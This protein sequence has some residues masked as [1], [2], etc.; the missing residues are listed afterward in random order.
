M[1]RF[2][3]FILSSSS[4]NQSLDFNTTIWTVFRSVYVRFFDFNEELKQTAVR[5]EIFPNYAKELLRV[6]DHPK[7]G[8]CI[9]FM[10]DEFKFY[11][12]YY[13]RAEYE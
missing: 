12:L 6:R 1:V 10:H 4:Q 2:M 9:T 8:I 5:K 11:G 7:F 13:L 3:F